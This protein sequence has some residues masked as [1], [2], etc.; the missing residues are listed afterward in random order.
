MCLAAVF[1][2][3]LV[4]HSAN[5]YLL[6]VVESVWVVWIILGLTLH[7]SC[8]VP[9]REVKVGMNAVNVQNQLARV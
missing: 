2:G 6:P 9:L 4:L 7:R 8:S 1:E 3:S 5:S